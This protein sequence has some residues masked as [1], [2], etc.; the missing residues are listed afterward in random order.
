MA[1]QF[2]IKLKNISK[3]SVWRRVIVSEKM[4]F[5]EFHE[6]IQV[7]FHWENYHLYF[8]SPSGYGSHPY[9][10]EPD[11][12]DEIDMEA[13]ATRLDEVFGDAYR[14]FQYCY[15][16]GDDWVHEI[17]LEEITKEKIRRPRCVA[18]KG[19]CPPEDCGGPWGYQNMKE[20]MNNPDHE[21][22]SDFKEWLGI[23]GVW[24]PSCFDQEEVNR[25][26]AACFND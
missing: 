18:G 9:I 1:F 2:K 23:E 12:D 15:D 22:H 17:E 21:E 3:P 6:T 25:Q 14:Q 13:P 24:D 20:I 26:L 16:L 4:T 10:S 7:L 19:A 11:N 5:Y 8:F